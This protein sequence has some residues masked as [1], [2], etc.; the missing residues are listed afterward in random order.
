MRAPASWVNKGCSP[1]RVKLEFAMGANLRRHHLRFHN[2]SIAVAA[3]EVV[4]GLMVEELGR[5][6]WPAGVMP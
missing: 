4:V 5:Q 6:P 3:G 1:A 2:P